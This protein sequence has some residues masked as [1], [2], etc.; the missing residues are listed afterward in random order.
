M[1]RRCFS[2]R[3][4]TVGLSSRRCWWRILYWGMIMKKFVFG[5]AALGAML[6]TGPAQAANVI[7]NGGFESGNLGPWLE[8]STGGPIALGGFCPSQ[9]RSWTVSTSGSATGCSPAGNPIEG[10]KAAYVM[11]DGPGNTTYS[12]RQS[13]I[14][15]SN[16]TGLNL[17]FLFSSVS[18]YSGGVR[19]FDANLLNSA[20]SIISNLFHYNVPFGD[21]SSAWDSATAFSTAANGFSGQQ[22]FLEFRNF[23]PQAW[24]GPAGLGLDDVNLSLTTSVGT[25][26]VPE[27]ASWALMIAGF[28]LVGGAMRKR[29]VAPRVTFA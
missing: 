25:G 13:F 8:S 27:P 7:V 1:R 6:V 23:S 22:V 5:A 3:C 18:S 26:G 14:L 10:S 9:G 29:R 19:T 20:G 12:L 2:P 16:V 17:S 11:N 15:P 21:S 4:A 28:G 24:T